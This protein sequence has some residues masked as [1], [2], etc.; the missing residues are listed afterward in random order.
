[1]SLTPLVGTPDTTFY[2]LELGFKFRIRHIH[3]KDEILT[4]KLLDKKRQRVVH[5]YFFID[6]LY[7]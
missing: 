4:T 5:V 3:L 2:M 1:V 7:T 6:P